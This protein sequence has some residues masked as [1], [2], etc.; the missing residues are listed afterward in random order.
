MPHRIQKHAAVI[1]AGTGDRA[2][3]KGAAPRSERAVVFNRDALPAQRD[4]QH[5][6]VGSSTERGLI[7]RWSI[8]KSATAARMIW[9]GR[10]ND[11]GSH[12]GDQNPSLEFPN[13][14]Y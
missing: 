5:L 2:P 14:R 3:A 7:P 13:E 8:V 1:D 9:R 4:G 10:K 12:K 11:L 6:P